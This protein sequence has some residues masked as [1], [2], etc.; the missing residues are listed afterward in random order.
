MGI[1]DD[2]RVTQASTYGIQFISDEPTGVGVTVDLGVSSKDGDDLG[3]VA[4][5]QI[6]VPAETGASLVAIQEEAVDRALDLLERLVAEDRDAVKR[7]L[8]VPQGFDISKR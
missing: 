2:R 3:P 5:V 4:T 6:F 8:F 1:F 7:L